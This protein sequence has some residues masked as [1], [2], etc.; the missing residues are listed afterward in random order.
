MVR[1][2]ARVNGQLESVAL[3]AVDITGDPLASRARLVEEAAAALNCEL[4][5]PNDSCK[6]YLK[7]GASITV[8][9]IEKDED[10]SFD[11][12]G[13]HECCSDT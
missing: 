13:T 9:H 11:F 8:A 12:G 5:V 4:R 1:V 7:G 3:V 2:I 10:I 6:I